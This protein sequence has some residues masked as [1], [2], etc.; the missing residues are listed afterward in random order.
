[1]NRRLFLNRSLIICG[2]AGLSFIGCHSDGSSNNVTSAT[3]GSQPKINTKAIKLESTA[4]KANGSIPIKYTCDGENISPSLIWEQPPS[5]TQTLTLI[6]DD[7]DAPGGRFAHWVLYNIPATVHQL[8]EKIANA[9]TLPNGSVQGKND[10]GKLV[11][12]GPCPPNGTHRYFFKL[13]ALDK[14]LEIEPSA[15]QAQILSAIDG[16][17]LAQG[18]LVGFYRRR[19]T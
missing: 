13:Y 19:S 6:V 18:E 11:Y 1:M 7:P 4:F 12:G 3:S 5:G 14:K 8:P 9:R 17:V 16:H 15:N 2:L 10:F